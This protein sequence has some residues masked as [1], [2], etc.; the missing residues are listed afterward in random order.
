MD[1]SPHGNARASRGLLE[2]HSEIVCQIYSGFYN[3]YGIPYFKIWQAFSSDSNN[4]ATWQ[5]VGLRPGHQ[6]VVLG[7]RCIV[8]W[9]NIS[10]S[11]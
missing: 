5:P 7:L 2:T 4:N 1:C 10:L 3:K 9:E 8:A 11:L 6:S